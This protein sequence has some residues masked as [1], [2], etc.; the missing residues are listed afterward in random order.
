MRVLILLLFLIACAP[1]APKDDVHPP[2]APPAPPSEAAR[3]EAPA[4]SDTQPALVEQPRPEITIDAITPGNPLVVSGL[5]RT[6]E[7][8]VQVR[9]L[10]KDGTPIAAQHTTSAGEMGN[11]NPYR[12]ELWLVRD[13]DAVTVEAFEYSAKDG[14][15]RSRVVR[16]EQL[17][18][19]SFEQSL[20]WP[21][22]DCD[23]FVTLRR[24]MPRSAGVA[25][26]LV[27]ALVAGPDASDRAAGATSPFPAR[28][29]VKSVVLREG[30][31]TV[32][33]SE[34]LQNV[35]GACAATAIRESVTRTLQALPAV[36]RVEITAG[37]SAALA[38]QP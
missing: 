12:A 4:P 27:E 3:P 29:E 1:P 25:R 21:A 20:V 30:V 24:R 28:S 22:G 6:F 36:K 18:L 32:D 31:L 19:P 10:D 35:G 2:D 14:S 5:A 33:L 13:V 38:L 23:R 37:G 9:V 8:T 11:H 7:N 17:A 15:I 34:R 16:E 26:L